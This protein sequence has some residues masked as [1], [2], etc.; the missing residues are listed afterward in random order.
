M[1]SDLQKILG[2]LP[3]LS[4][5][6]LDLLSVHVKAL[7]QLP[8]NGR[9]ETI[10]DN[11]LDDVV[12][13][14]CRTLESCGS[15]YVNATVLSRRSTPSIRENIAQLDKY[16]D[17]V[18]KEKNYRTAFLSIAV[19]LLYED[20]LRMGIPVSGRTIMMHLHRIPGIIN[21]NFPGYAENGLLD[22]IVGGGKNI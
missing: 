16:I 2:M 22:K 17:K 10:A 15:G 8:S 6:D 13:T 21:T 3:S 9:N 20:L 18:S 12:N 5:T 1:P 14:I 19:R 4:V 11:S 7:R